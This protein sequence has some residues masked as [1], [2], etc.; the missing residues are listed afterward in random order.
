M[1]SNDAKRA[2]TESAVL[3]AP[4]ERLV[5]MLYDGAIRFLSQSAIAMRAQNGRV[6]LDRVQRGEAIISELNL[7]LDMSQGE[8][9]ERLRAIYQFCNMHLAAATMEH[10]PKK[11]DEVVRLLSDLREAWQQIA[12][13]PPAAATAAAA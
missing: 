11:I 10:D 12:A 5:V 3:T 13:A 7:T 8:V 1:N 2:Y 6:F 9:A 4:P